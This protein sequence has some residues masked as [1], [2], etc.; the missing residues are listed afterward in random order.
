MRGGRQVDV[1]SLMRVSSGTSLVPDELGEFHPRN[2]A[3]PANSIGPESLAGV[4]ADC[5]RGEVDFLL[6]LGQ[7]EE[8]ERL[9]SS[10]SLHRHA[11]LQ[12]GARSYREPVKLEYPCNSFPCGLYL[13]F[14]RQHANSPKFH[15]KVADT[16]HSWFF[17][18]RF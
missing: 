15:E 10:V 9:A 6:G 11:R 7:S 4:G 5:V 12:G 16:F 2:E 3:G 1:W 14:R 18:Q 8:V 13:A 17:F